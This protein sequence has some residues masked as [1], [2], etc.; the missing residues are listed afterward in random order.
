MSK[1]H[2]LRTFRDLT[3][4]TPV[5]FLSA[6]RIH[7]AKRLLYATTL[8]VAEISVRVGYGSLGTFTRRFTEC[9]GLPPTLYRRA[10]RGEPLPMPGENQQAS[11]PQVGTVSGTVH[12]A[13]GTSAPILIGMFGSNMPQGRP[14]ACASVN[15]PGR[16][17][18]S[19]VPAGSWH[20][21][22]V[23]AADP[24]EQ[25]DSTERP[26]MVGTTGRVRVEAGG[27]ADVDVTIRP[28]DWTH[29]P[30]LIVLPGIE[31]LRAAA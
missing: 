11:G 7:E 9:V 27:H 26:L 13:P 16:W 10:A 5:R 22:A 17:E 1:F 25:A 28:V 12:A 24:A 14:V 3:G 18:M 19:R 21:I 20:L 6:V 8:N 30:L 2:F 4:V 29:P 23:A 15:E 31:A